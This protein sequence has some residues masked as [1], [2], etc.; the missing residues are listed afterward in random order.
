[1]GKAL[2]ETERMHR[3]QFVT[4]SRAAIGLGLSLD[5][6]FTARAKQ[7]ETWTALIR[8]RMAECH[9]TDP[10]EL[11]PELL[12]RVQEQAV[13]AARAAAK[14]AAREEVKALDRSSPE[15]GR[16]S[17]ILLCRTSADCV[18]KVTAEKL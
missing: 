9:V 16:P 10:V 2:S 5:D 18:A 14:T 4:D 6:C 12:V 1:M 15:S 11:L 8:A 13:G 17:A 7:V 3:R